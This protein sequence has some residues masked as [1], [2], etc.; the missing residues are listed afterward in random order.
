VN[1]AYAASLS[2]SFLFRGLD[3]ETIACTLNCFR[4]ERR[5]ARTS[6]FVQGD[7]ARN[8]HIIGEGRVKTTRV[9]ESGRELALAIL[10]PDEILG[11]DVL[12]DN[13]TLRSTTAMCLEDS[14][15]HTISAQAFHKL[16]SS[17]P[18]I[19]MNVARQCVAKL[20]ATFNSIED[21]AGLPVPKRI[22]GLLERLA[23]KYGSE[24]EHGTRIDVPLTHHEVAALIGSTRETV[25]LEIN[26]LIRAGR[27]RVQRRQF[28]L[29][30]AFSTKPR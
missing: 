30:S 29:L 2:T 14:V 27:L 4:T 12:L 17:D 21:L 18:I 10:G 15:I 25:S 8:V 13:A 9:T 20:D 5:V 7:A 16:S 3:H 19:A 11:E 28:L 1:V 23:I 26:N 6:L 22:L 24:V